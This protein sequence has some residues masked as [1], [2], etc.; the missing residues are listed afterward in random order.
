MHDIGRGLVTLATLVATVRATPG[1]DRAV[2]DRMDLA[3]QTID[4][5]L[6][7]VG[8]PGRRP[9]DEARACGPVDV[10][11]V[12]E[13]VVACRDAASS[14]TAVL[15][16]G[17]GIV[18]RLDALD[19]LNLKRLV[20]NLVDNAIRAAG[21]TGRVEVELRDGPRPVVRVL[22]DGPGPDRG[23]AGDLGMGLGI[24]ATLA[25]RLAAEVTLRPRSGRGAVA[26]IVLGGA[27]SST[28]PVR[29][30]RGAPA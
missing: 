12:V 30:G 21:P 22:D 10:R 26:E 13:G 5:L 15:R 17:P 20:A 14:T 2:A 7:L 23:P 16:P 29:S 4:G 25:R 11:E 6:D 24:V 28:A 19:A 27:P 1:P 3:A 9:G 8:D 18:L